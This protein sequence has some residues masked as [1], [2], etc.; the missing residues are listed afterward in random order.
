[1]D[2]DPIEIP[3]QPIPFKYGLVH[4]SQSLTKGQSKIVAICSSTTAGEGDVVPY[5]G[6]LLQ[7]LQCEYSTAIVAMVNK[8]ISSQEAPI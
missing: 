4:F 3:V 1:V 5:P 8:G 6:R 7:S 2:N